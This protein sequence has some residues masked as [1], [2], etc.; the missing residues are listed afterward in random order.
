MHNLI[1]LKTEVIG[2]RM[3]CMGIKCQYALCKVFSSLDMVLA[4]DFDL[5]Q[6]VVRLPGD[7]VDLLEQFLLVILQFAHHAG[8]RDLE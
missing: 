4:Q 6:V 7:E 1:K 3:D 5:V 2:Q 8:S